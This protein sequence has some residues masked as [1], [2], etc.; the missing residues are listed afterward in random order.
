[1]NACLCVCLHAR[2]VRPMP[3]F[4]LSGSRRLI[5][6]RNTLGRDQTNPFCQ[7]DFGMVS[8]LGY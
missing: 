8:E 6:R 5:H 3:P 1:M 4:R 7:F 2:Q